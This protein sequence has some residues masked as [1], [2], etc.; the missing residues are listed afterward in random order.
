MTALIQK[1]T[2]SQCPFDQEEKSTLMCDKLTT[3]SLCPMS[4]SGAPRILFTLLGTKSKVLTNQAH[5]YFGPNK[6]DTS[7]V[8]H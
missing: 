4:L 8:I 6:H 7:I 5:K 1:P 2:N 3:L